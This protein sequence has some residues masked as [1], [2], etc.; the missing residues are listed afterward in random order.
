[1][2]M[3]TQESAQEP[4]F[5]GAAVCWIWADFT[6]F[7]LVLLFFFFF[8]LLPLKDV[9]FVIP[10]ITMGFACLFSKEH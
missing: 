3:D 6:M 4:G 2:V 8:F 1:M 7:I 9:E 5:S 10:G